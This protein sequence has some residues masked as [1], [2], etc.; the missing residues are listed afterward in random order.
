M[1]AVAFALVSIFVAHGLVGPLDP[2]ATH[3]TV[4]TWVSLV[5]LLLPCS[6]STLS[7]SLDWSSKPLSEQGCQQLSWTKSVFTKRMQDVSALA[8]SCYQ[9]L[10]WD[11]ST[12]LRVIRRC[13]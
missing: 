10:L 8:S 5:A 6:H 2:S 12:S 4:S 7:C 3:R 13:I 11:R 1:G 9:R